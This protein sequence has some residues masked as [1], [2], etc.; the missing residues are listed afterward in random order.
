[1]TDCEKTII[2][3]FAGSH[4]WNM[5]D[6]I[7]EVENLADDMAAYLDCKLNMVSFGLKLQSSGLHSHRL[8]TLPRMWKRV[9]REV[10]GGNIDNIS[11]RSIP[12]PNR[13]I[14]AFDW[15]VLIDCGFFPDLGLRLI[16]VGLD[17]DQLQSKLDTTGLKTLLGIC[18]RVCRILSAEYGYMTNMPRVFLPGG[19]AIGLMGRAPDKLIY[20]ANS[21]SEG[22]SREFAT[23]IRN[24]HPV[25]F[26]TA[27]HLEQRVR[28]EELHA[29]INEDPQ[30]GELNTWNDEL[31]LWSFVRPDDELAMSMRW[32]NPSVVAVRNVLE[33]ALFFPWQVW[34]VKYSS[35]P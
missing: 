1:M 7:S 13:D 25:N 11:L 34:L 27:A 2:A 22:A 14:A 33:G 3:F 23:K 10:L 35:I 17:F 21:W 15:Q 5:S 30:R 29:W 18:A 32:S 12:N 6:Q 19:Y 4:A 9:E 20:D 16:Q 24:V 31:H 26:V 8:Y 28:H